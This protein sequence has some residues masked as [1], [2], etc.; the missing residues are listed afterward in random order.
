MLTHF[1]TFLNG[2][3]YQ[4]TFTSY[5]RL[6]QLLC[7]IG[8]GQR[9]HVPPA[10]TLPCVKGCCLCVCSQ[11]SML[12][13]VESGRYDT[14]EDF[15]VVLQPFLL[16]IRL[17]VLEVYS[18]TPI[19]SSGGRTAMGIFAREQPRQECMCFH[20]MRIRQ[21][22]HRE[23]CRCYASRHMQHLS[24]DIMLPTDKIAT[25]VFGDTVSLTEQKCRDVTYPS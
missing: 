14:R 19:L 9:V 15:T 3:C 7:P 8:W 25:T 18:P 17:P 12:Q 20:C 16:N 23:I 6:S 4:K 10:L 5:E 1:Q 2:I 22:G 13:L 11:S 24:P 21:K